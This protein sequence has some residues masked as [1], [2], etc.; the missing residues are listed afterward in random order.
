MEQN[1]EILFGV[2]QRKINELTSQNIAWEAK[3][4]E[5]S[6]QLQEL[7]NTTRSKTVIKKPDAGEF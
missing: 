3:A 7:Q 4:I 6:Q 5:L 1:Y 2:Y